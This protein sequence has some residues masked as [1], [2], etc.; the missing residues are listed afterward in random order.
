MAN[1]VSE[2][3]FM[4]FA[5]ARGFGDPASMIGSPGLFGTLK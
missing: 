5:E 3:I 1:T 2:E 4:R